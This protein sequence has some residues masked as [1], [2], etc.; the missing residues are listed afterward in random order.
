[1]IIPG[2]QRVYEC[3][4]GLL[5]FKILWHFHALATLT[6]S[7]PKLRLLF[8]LDN[9]IKSST[10]V[11]LWKQQLQICLVGPTVTH[12]CRAFRASEVMESFRGEANS[13]LF[14]TEMTEAA[15]AG[16]MTSPRTLRRAHLLRPF[17]SGSHNKLRLSLINGHLKD[18]HP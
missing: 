17:L 15:R 16:V 13:Q 10:G 1:M 8:M 14:N 9:D 2:R 11:R 5:F 6:G 18:I 4:W 12:L 3:E 7:S